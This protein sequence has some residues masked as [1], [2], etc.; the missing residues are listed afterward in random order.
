MMSCIDLELG[1]G[2]VEPLAVPALACSLACWVCVSRGLGY[3]HSH[4]RLSSQHR[5]LSR[6]IVCVLLVMCHVV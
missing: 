3:T 5:A 1:A 4:P 6:L 2:A